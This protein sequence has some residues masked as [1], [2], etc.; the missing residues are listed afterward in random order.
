MIAG[1]S[2]NVGFAPALSVIAASSSIG[3]LGITTTCCT[4]RMKFKP[5]LAFIT[6]SSMNICF[7]STLSI[8]LV[9]DQAGRSLRVA[10]TN[11]REFLINWMMLEIK[12]Y[13]QFSVWLQNGKPK[14]KS[15]HSVHFSPWM[16]HLQ[17][18]CPEA[19]HPSVSVPLGWQ[20]Q[21]SMIKSSSQVRKSQNKI[22]IRKNRPMSGL[23]AWVW[24]AKSTRRARTTE[25]FIL[26]TNRPLIHSYRFLPYLCSLTIINVEI[27]FS[28]NVYRVWK[29]GQEN[30]SWCFM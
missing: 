2:F 24:V 20:L 22:N 4:I 18:H 29:Q 26:R 21:T 19:S 7:A 17:W 6:L 12:F 15:V 8:G 30:Q 28:I 1:Q 25:V 16:S 9:A 27:Q 5:I 14:W 3:S 23:L 10:C 13:I 11:Y